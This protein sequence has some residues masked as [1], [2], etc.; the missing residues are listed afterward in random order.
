[1]VCAGDEPLESNSIDRT[2]INKLQNVITA[3]HCPI[4]SIEFTSKYTHASDET[5]LDALE[6]KQT[7]PKSGNFV[8][9]FLIL[10]SKN[11]K[12]I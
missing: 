6:N 9:S 5:K 11:S 10:C 1:L 7:N 2:C 12:F 8:V 3:I 4:N